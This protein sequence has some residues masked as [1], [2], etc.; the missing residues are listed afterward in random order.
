MVSPHPRE[1]IHDSDALTRADTTKLLVVTN[2][3]C[4]RHGREYSS[5]CVVQSPTPAAGQSMHLSAQLRQRSAAAPQHE[6]ATIEEH[7]RKGYQ[8]PQIENMKIRRNRGPESQQSVMW[9]G[10]NEM[11][12]GVQ[13]QKVFAVA[14]DR[15]G[16]A[17]D[18]EGRD[19]VLA[20]QAQPLWHRPPH[21]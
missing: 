15:S 13:A 6:S 7:G 9:L 18:A 12:P 10:A 1:Q 21:P 14:R 11:A 17:A 16:S 5:K 2:K 20:R 3:C 4:R 8:R 19:P